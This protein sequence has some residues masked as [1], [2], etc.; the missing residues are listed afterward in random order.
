MVRVVSKRGMEKG[1]VWYRIYGKGME[2]IGKELVEVSCVEVVVVAC[3]E[4]EELWATGP[5]NL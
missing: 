2:R 5:H 1:V 4:E 3:C